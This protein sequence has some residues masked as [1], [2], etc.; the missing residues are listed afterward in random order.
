MDF[1]SLKMVIIY[2]RQESS[3]LLW[4]YNC[5]FNNINH[6]F[7][8]DILSFLDLNSEKSEKIGRG[9]SKSFVAWLGLLLGHIWSTAYQN[10]GGYS[11]PIIMAGCSKLCTSWKTHELEN[12]RVYVSPIFI[13]DTNVLNI[14]GFE[15][16]PI[17][18]FI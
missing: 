14:V 4:M 7:M 10:F 3:I 18:I 11:H 17:F 15:V 2:C 1:F 6:W 5:L 13:T 8:A 12:S 16:S 9:R